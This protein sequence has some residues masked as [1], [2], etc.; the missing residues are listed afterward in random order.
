MDITTTVL[1]IGSAIIDQLAK[2]DD[3]ITRHQLSA[4]IEAI[5]RQHADRIQQV[6]TGGQSLA[7]TDDLIDRANAVLHTA[8]DIVTVGVDTV[9]NTEQVIE[10]VIT[11][12]FSGKKKEE[13]KPELN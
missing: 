1:T 10:D 9:K 4:E 11:E 13:I 12:V 7:V 6:R 5:L 2:I 3:V 8:A